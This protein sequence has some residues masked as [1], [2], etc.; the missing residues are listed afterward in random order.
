M[1]TGKKRIL[2]FLLAMCMTLSLLPVSAWAAAGADD[3]HGDHS[4]WTELNSYIESHDT[5]QTG[6]YYLTGNLDA[7][8]KQI[9]VTGTVNLCLNGYTY[10]G[11]ATDG[12]LRV[13]S[14]G[15]LNIYDCSANGSGMIQSMN[16]HNPIFLHS[17]GVCNLYGGTIQSNRTAVVIDN[18]QLH[19]EDYEGGTLNSTGG[20]FTM[21]GGTVTYHVR[22][23]GHLHFH[24]EPGHQRQSELDKCLCD[25]RGWYGAQRQIRHQCRQRHGEAVRRP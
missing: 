6:N 16:N 5:L 2:S 22:R 23:Y 20:T 15:I 21:Y 1:N 17:G 10:T 24:R 9:K 4:D 19:N 13:G 3:D 7:D 12:V 18:N 8:T 14:G 25:N 11:E